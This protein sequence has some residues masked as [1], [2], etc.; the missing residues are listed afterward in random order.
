MTRRAPEG[1]P[2]AQELYEQLAKA[3]GEAKRGSWTSELPNVA[4]RWGAVPLTLG[5]AI[6]IFGA[7]VKAWD[8][9][10]Q[11]DQEVAAK[12]ERMLRAHDDA[13][14]AHKEVLADVKQRIA[15]LDREIGDLQARMRQ[16]DE[17][18]EKRRKR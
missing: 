9:A 7:L 13:A 2:E 15:Q 18:N 8:V 17:A 5:M 6:G 11:V 10:R 16:Q 3:A 1:P 12:V 14:S 4:R